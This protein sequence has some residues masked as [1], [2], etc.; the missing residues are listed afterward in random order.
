MNDA[1]P[2]GS[3]VRLAVLGLVVFSMFAT[4]FVRLW[5]L[6][7]LRVEDH[8]VAAIENRF[9]T[10]PVRAPRGRILDRNGK[11]LVD[12][13]V[14]V[15]V[16][17]DPQVLDAEMPEPAERSRYIGRLARDLRSF[18]VDVSAAQI[19][20]RLD[21]PQYSPLSP[22]PI[23]E[24]VPED[25]EIFLGEHASEFPATAVERRTVRTYP[26]GQL[27]AHILGY[28]GALNEEEYD[29]EE[30]VDT[31][32][33]YQVDDEIGKTGVER[34]FESWLRGT[35]GERVVQTDSANRV[36]GEVESEGIDPQ[37]GSDVRLTIDIDL[38]AAAEE[39]LEEKLLERREVANDDDLLFPAP[40]GAV[41]MEDPR[42]GDLLA[43]ASYPTY[44]PSEFLGGI[45]EDRFNVLNSEENGAP[46]FSRAIQGTY[47]PASTFKLVTAFAALGSGMITPETTFEDQGIYTLTDCTGSSCVR[48]NAGG[49]SNGTVDVRRALTVSSDV[50]FYW[51]G[52]SLWREESLPAN[53]IQ[54]TATLFGFGEETGVPLPE[55]S[56]A[57]PTPEEREALKEEAESADP[58][59]YVPGWRAGDNVNLAIGQGDLLVTPLQLTNAYSIIAN[60]G[61]RFQPNIADAVVEIDR[62]TG[63]QTILQ[64]F[65]P[66]EATRVDLSA[67]HRDPIMAGLS[68]VTTDEEGTAFEAFEGFDPG[69]PV[70]GKTGTTN[71]VTNAWFIGFT[72]DLVTTSWVGFDLPAPIRR[73]AQGGRD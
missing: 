12:N 61:T 35:P 47:A 26:Y 1:A 27:A 28:V 5:S 33:P 59:A 4:L 20:E 13:R 18:G 39:A 63:E 19:S 68:G 7:V 48:T 8:E 72:P 24:D 34:V 11:V 62:Q 56:G 3:M 9:E 44:D 31:E 69:W 10:L 40:A 30:R 16:T 37:P 53:G 55:A 21:D 64:E 6:Q 42:D 54:D 36:V 45:S 70:A 43:V 17:L 66:R 73:D 23:A 22:R 58:D 14:S 38:Q 29:R 41:V 60:G 2:R 52:E 51:I 65:G 57:V 67:A 32:K 46:L 49:V 25:V 15:V 71:E 50:F